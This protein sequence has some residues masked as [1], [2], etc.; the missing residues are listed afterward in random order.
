[1]AMSQKDE[2]AHHEELVSGLYEQLMPVMENSSQGM[3]LYLDD[4]HNM[5]NDQMAKMLGYSSGAEMKRKANDSPLDAFI[6]IKSHKSV[7]NAFRNAMEKM[8]GSTISV[9][10]KK[11]S[12]GKITKK[13]ILVPISYHGH[14][15]ALHFLY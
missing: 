10:F 4:T 13:M 9:T 3:Y 5:F 15:F 6:D 1:M 12:G 2:H 14:L 7:V 11:K 8:A